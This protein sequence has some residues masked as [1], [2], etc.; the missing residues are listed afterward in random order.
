M[1][2]KIFFQNNFRFRAGQFVFLQINHFA[3][4]Q[5][6]PFSI[7]SAPGKDVF[8]VHIKNL[9]DW[10]SNLTKTDLSAIEAGKLNL[11]CKLDGMS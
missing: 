10:T 4:F 5:W 8:T 7:S 1:F 9:G 11:S 3:L 6:H 2:I